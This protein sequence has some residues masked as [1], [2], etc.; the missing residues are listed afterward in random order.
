M[1][2][3]TTATRSAPRSQKP[4]PGRSSGRNGSSNANQQPKGPGQSAERESLRV[5]TF[6]SAG[7]RKFA[8][9]LQKAKNGNPCLRIVQGVPQPD[10]TYRKFDLTF[11]SEDFAAL[12]DALD[13][14]REH[15]EEHNIRTP[16]G[17]A[18]KPGGK[19]K[20]GSKRP[21]KQK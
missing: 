13:A 7:D 17:H 16:D 14:M 2:T 10:G 9:Q 8:L 12:F 20:G 18:W 19:G 4:Q 6:D 15:I 21:R 1:A 11:W 5:I 3:S